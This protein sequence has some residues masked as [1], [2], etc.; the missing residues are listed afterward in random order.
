[1]NL[2]RKPIP[3]FCA[4]CGASAPSRCLCGPPKSPEAVR[5]ALGA[6]TARERAAALGWRIVK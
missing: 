3:V 6:P 1:V 2:R 5:A 4:A